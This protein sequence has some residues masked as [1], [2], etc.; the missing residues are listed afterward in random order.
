MRGSKLKEKMICG[1]VGGWVGGWVGRRAS[2][3]GRLIEK[4]SLL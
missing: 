1:L 4:S 3:D 2:V